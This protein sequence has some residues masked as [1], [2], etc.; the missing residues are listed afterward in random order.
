[1]SSSKAKRERQLAKEQGGVNKRAAEEL[2]RQKAK[3]NTRKLIVVAA[4]I[5]VVLLA[6][7]IVLNS[8]FI[9]RD[10]TAITI[11]DMEL[12]VAEYEFFYYNCFYEYYS[13]VYSSEMATYATELLPQSGVPHASQEYKD[14]ETW[15]DFFDKYTYDTLTR[16]V[17]IYKQAKDA[18]FVLSD[19]AVAEI[20]EEIAGLNESALMYGYTDVEKYITSLYGSSVTMDILKE[21]TEFL[22]YVLEYEEYYNDSLVY[23][24]DEIDAQYESKKDMYDLYEYRYFLVSGEDIDKYSYETDEE[25]EAAQTDAQQAAHSIAEGYVARI[26][27]EEDFIAVA[28]E[29]D[30]EAYGEEDSTL[31]RYNGNLLGSVYGDWLRESSRKYGDITLADMNTGTYVV[32][33]VGRED[34]HYDTVNARMLVVPVDS[35][36]A[37]DYADEEDDTAYNEAVEAA[38]EDARVEAEDI[39]QQ[40]KD[41]GGTTELFDEYIDEY[42]MNY[43]YDGGFEEN[44]YQ[45]KYS[46]EINDWLYDP[47]RAEGDTTIIYSENMASYY[48]ICFSGTGDVYAEAMA[49]DDLRQADVDVWEASLTEGVEI[50]KTWLYS[51]EKAGTQLVGWL[52]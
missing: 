17:G 16:Y 31:R 22:H 51:L 32:F 21:C 20:D 34:N 48:I 46:K 25:A 35:V 12:S 38:K 5:I 52:Q 40:W 6:I 41:E 4:V 10:Y 27:S 2:E 30:S 39:L 47:A 13:Y 9:R 45:D 1:M 43:A 37:D 23:T 18:G 28:K 8:K 50:T 15:K 42:Y 7:A 49:E 36:N 3:K 33:F 29:H 19:E 24:D 14:G 44:I 26:N 11:G